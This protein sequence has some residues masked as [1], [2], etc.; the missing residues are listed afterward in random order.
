MASTDTQTAGGPEV[1]AVAKYIRTSPRKLR[2]VADLIRGK[3]VSDARVILQFTP[4]RAAATLQKVLESAIA[5]AENNEEL[6]AED[7][8]IHKIF[9]DEGPTMKRWVPRARGRASAIK[10]RTS[11]VTVV[12][13]AREEA[14]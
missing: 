10:K 2:L 14:R 9:V 3:S 11:H 12:V 1:R 8:S 13:K 4:K 5:N 6:D 7:L